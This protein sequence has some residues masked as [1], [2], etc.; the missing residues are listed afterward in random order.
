MTNPQITELIKTCSPTLLNTHSYVQ[1]YKAIMARIVFLAEAL[2]H[3]RDSDTL[4]PQIL[5]DARHHQTVTMEFHAL[6]DIHNTIDHLPDWSTKWNKYR[7]EWTNLNLSILLKLPEPKKAFRD[8]ATEE[9]LRIQ[10]SSRAS[11]AKQRIHL[12]MKQAHAAGWFVV[13]DSLTLKDDAIA[14]FYKDENALRDYCRDIGRKVLKAEKRKLTES[15]TN[16][17]QYIIVPEYGTK[18]GR[19]HFHVVHLMRTLP[20]GSFD[21]N[22]GKITTKRIN[23]I[24]PSLRN[25]WKYGFS[26]PLT[27]RYSGDAFT[28]R[29]G[30]LH[31]TDETGKPIELKP[32][33]AVG[34]YVSKYISKQQ[35]QYDIKNNLDKGTK[36]NQTLSKILNELPMHTFRVRMSRGFGMKLDSMAHLSNEA[37]IQLT[38]LHYTVTPYNK[39]L[40]ASA[41]KE[42][43]LRLATLIIS[44]LPALMPP[45]I[46][47]LESLRNSMKMSA[48]LNLV[49]FTT[50]LTPKLKVTDISNEVKNYLIE[51]DTYKCTET[52]RPTYCA[53]SK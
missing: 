20:E 10:S 52:Y 2:G 38:K 35:D 22:F 40:S 47:L 46:N 49:N 9:L 45:A 24:L 6:L 13:F 19:L 23:R 16:S 4:T 8:E 12:A 25:Q 15:Y 18:H 29:L 28:T 26:K 11:Y 5:K 34:F 44:D 7:T 41:K 37:L 30:W 36:W 14:Q 1:K 32:L 27:V 31:P 33:L 51:S 3:H 48:T 17:Y 21:P 53:G 43:K 50:I 39:I 42:I